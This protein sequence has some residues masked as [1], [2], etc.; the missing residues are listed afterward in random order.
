MAPRITR[1]QA[2]LT[3][4]QPINPIKSFDCIICGRGFYEEKK[5]TSH[6]EER[7]HEQTKL[8]CKLCGTCFFEEE[9]MRSHYEKKHKQRIIRIE[10]RYFRISYDHSKFTRIVKKTKSDNQRKQSPKIIQAAV[11]PLQ[12]FVKEEET[13]PNLTYM[14]YKCGN[15]DSEQTQARR[16]PTRESLFYH[17]STHADITHYQCHRCNNLIIQRR[18]LLKHLWNVHTKDEAL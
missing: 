10:T 11:E 7:H 2:E 17:F 9:E 3:G 1:R 6:Y 12:I 8:V 5:L 15:S 13:E 4:L 14:C 16:F 18:A